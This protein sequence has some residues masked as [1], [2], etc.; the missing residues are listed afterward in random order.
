[1]EFNFS[2]SISY[3]DFLQYYQGYVDKI[4][5]RDHHSG[6][7]LW[8][9][10]RYFRKFLTVNGLQGQFKLILNKQGEFESLTKQ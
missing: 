4:E 3:K 9:H 1:M 7:T 2:V 5:V 8:I 10:A 6:K